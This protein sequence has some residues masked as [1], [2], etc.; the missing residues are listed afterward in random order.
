MSEKPQALIALVPTAVVIDG[1][2]VVIAPGEPLPPMV[3]AERAELVAT[4]AARAAE[5]HEAEAA[6]AAASARRKKK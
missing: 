1:E 3:D 6:Q 2:R 5:D 4:R